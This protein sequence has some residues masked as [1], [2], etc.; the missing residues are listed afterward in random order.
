MFL[1]DLAPS[2]RGHFV[3]FGPPASLNVFLRK[4][5]HFHHCRIPYNFSF[6][7][8]YYGTEKTDASPIE[9][10]AEP[11]GFE[12]FGG[13]PVKASSEYYVIAVDLNAEDVDEDFYEENIKF[14]TV[15]TPAE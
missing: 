13:G 9:I 2:S 3:T 4:T 12:M 14:I 15:T 1:G 6:L 7:L 8:Q 5:E 10:T 11:D